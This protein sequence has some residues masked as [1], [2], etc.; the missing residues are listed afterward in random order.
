[1][2]KAFL[3]KK[4][5]ARD[6]YLSA[7]GAL[8]EALNSTERCQVSTSLGY[9]PLFVMLFCM[10]VIDKGILKKCEIMLLVATAGDYLHQSGGPRLRL[11]S[12]LGKSI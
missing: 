5:T 2:I 3:G 11:N 10:L 7:K 1:M 9:K 12:D 8:L 4:E 6:A